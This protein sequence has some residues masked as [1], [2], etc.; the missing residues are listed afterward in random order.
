[1]INIILCG[2]AYSVC[3]AIS[4]IDFLQMKQCSSRIIY[5]VKIY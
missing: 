1:M 4:K 3:T 5:S 2:I